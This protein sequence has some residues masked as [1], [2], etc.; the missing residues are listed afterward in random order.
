VTTREELKSTID[1]LSLE[2]I[3]D[4][5]RFIRQQIQH[6][7]PKISLSELLYALAEPM[8]PEQ[9]VDFN[10]TVKRRPWRSESI[11]GLD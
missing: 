7:A 6:K 1:A 8:T 5:D 4:V 11:E 9:T 10:E 2:D 3:Q